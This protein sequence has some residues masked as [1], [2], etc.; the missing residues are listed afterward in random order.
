M[1]YVQAGLLLIFLGLI[2]LFAIQNMQSVTVDFM[3][4]S[5]NA[6]F[7]I[8][9]V[10]IYLLGMLTGWTV[11]AFVRRSLQRVSAPVRPHDQSA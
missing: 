7:A 4:W 1:R 11:I 6:P 2:G 3:T 8:L 9:A 10:I 5:I